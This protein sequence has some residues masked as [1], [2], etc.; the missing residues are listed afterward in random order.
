MVGSGGGR[1]DGGGN[2]TNSSASSNSSNSVLI[3]SSV[4][5][6]TVTDSIVVESSFW[7]NA[8]LIGSL[9]YC[10]DFVSDFSGVVGVSDDDLRGFFGASGH[11]TTGLTGVTAFVL[12]F[13]GVLDNT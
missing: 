1:V 6:C 13:L 8:R 7:K 9:S 10:F 11:L 3:S 12:C 5:S 2:S 4:S